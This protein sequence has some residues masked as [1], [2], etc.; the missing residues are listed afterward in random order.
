[1]T[2]TSSADYTPPGSWEMTLADKPEASPAKEDVASASSKANTT[3]PKR[4]SG[5][6]T[7][8]GKEAPK[9]AIK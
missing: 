4:Q 3:A 8:P 9:P 7:L 1:M 6:I 2:T 5:L